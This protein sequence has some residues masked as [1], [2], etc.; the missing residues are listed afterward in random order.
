MGHGC[1][2]QGEVGGC[3][4]RDDEGGPAR[5][6]MSALANLQC[7]LDNPHCTEEVC[8]AIQNVPILI[9][10]ANDQASVDNVVKQARV[11]LACAGP[12]AKYGA[13]VIVWQAP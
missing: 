2:Q 4:E 9:G 10:D 1:P 5:T 11:V 13:V 6:G 3:Q 7:A 12:Y 8:V